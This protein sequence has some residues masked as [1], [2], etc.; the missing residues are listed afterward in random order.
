MSI[1]EKKPIHPS[2]PAP[3]IHEV[4]APKEGVPQTS[5]RRLF[6]QLHIFQQC[7]DPN[8]VAKALE[9]SGLESVLYLDVNNPKGIGI[10][11]MSENPDRFVKDPLLRPAR[12]LLQGQAAPSSHTTAAAGQRRRNS[13]AR[14]HHTDGRAGCHH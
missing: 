12:A 8:S 5:D 13:T 2:I 3:A 9:Q 7:E 1:I 10:L 4:G 14:A 11:A 6:M